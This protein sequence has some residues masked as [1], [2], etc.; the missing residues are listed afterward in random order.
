MSEEVQPQSVDCWGELTVVQVWQDEVAVWGD[1]K[2]HTPLS[3]NTPT[4]SLPVHEQC[5]LYIKTPDDDIK[6]TIVKR[7]TDMHFKN[8]TTQ[9]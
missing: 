9:I 1:V 8:F 6:N 7:I 2:S 4:F 3:T 5:V